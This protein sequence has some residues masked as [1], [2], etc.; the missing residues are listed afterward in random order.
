MLLA[1]I[2]RDT[3][4]NILNYRIT[5]YWIILIN[6]F[7]IYLSP[8]LYFARQCLQLFPPYIQGVRTGIIVVPNIAV[9]TS[10][11]SIWAPD[12]RSR[13]Y[14]D[15]RLTSPPPTFSKFEFFFCTINLYADCMSSY[16][17]P[18]PPK[19]NNKLGCW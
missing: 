3:H 10:T 15:V 6:T 14:D 19:P 18:K 13:R 5:L 7:E 1:A 16:D 12:E 4:N 8:R 9:R 11:P 2:T 17:N